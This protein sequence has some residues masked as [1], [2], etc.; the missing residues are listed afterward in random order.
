MLNLFKTKLNKQIA[1]LL[2][3]SSNKKINKIGNSYNKFNYYP[4]AS[5]QWYDNVYSYNKN[6]SKLLL[7]ANNITLKLLKSYF[8]IYSRKLEKK[9]KSM[10]IRIRFRKL[11]TNKILVSKT[12][13]KH[14]NNKIMITACLYNRQKKYYT[15]KLKKSITTNKLRYFNR[16]FKIKKLINKSIYTYKKVLKQ[17]SIFFKIHKQNI[18]KYNN[19][20]NIYWKIFITKTLLKE[21]YTFQLNKLMYINKCKFENT[22]LL[23]FTHL[24]KSIYKKNIQFNFVSLKYLYLD[25]YLLTQTLVLKIRKYRKNRLLKVMKSAINMFNLPKFEKLPILDES[26]AIRFTAQNLIANHFNLCNNSN[27][28]SSVIN[29]NDSFN[30]VLDNLYPGAAS[31]N[32]KLSITDNNTDKNNV[33]FNNILNSIKH[34]S[35]TGIRIQA[36]GRLTRRNTAARSVS[37]VRYNGSLK[38]IASSVRGFSSVLFKGYSKSNLQ[39]TKLGSRIRIGSFGIKGWISS[40]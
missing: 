13:I 8:N 20:E 18:N 27:N 12:Q 37:K 33:M 5:K 14:S 38:D 39:Y 26:L 36:S 30:Q 24:I 25:S 16:T 19:Y 6:A 4:P 34:K 1:F 28:G 7:V 3:R 22:Y 40:N 2:Q 29:S 17:K 9:I 31:N 23:P 35:V 10:Y 15:E 32:S 11:S 21:I